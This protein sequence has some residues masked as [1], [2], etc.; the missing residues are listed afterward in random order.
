MFRIAPHRYLSAAGALQDLGEAVEPLGERAM[1]V[2]N[3]TAL[4]RF[5]DVIRSSL[6]ES[7]IGVGFEVCLG[8]CCLPEVERLADEA[9]KD[10]A[11]MIIGV[12][13]SNTLDVA[14]FTAHQLDSNLVTL[15][16]VAS[17]YAAFTNLVYL[18]SEDGE[19][20]EVKEL[21]TSPDLTIVDYKVVGL[22]PSRYLRA[23]MGVAIAT[24]YDIGISREELELHQP[25]KISFELSRHLRESLFESGPKALKDVKKGE[26]TGRVESVIEMNV[27]EAGLIS[28]LGGVTFRSMIAHQLARQLYPYS[29]EDILYGEVVS[30]TLIV[31][32]L[33]RGQTPSSL[34]DLMN[35]YRE[36]ELPLTL[37]S[38]GLPENQHESIL[39]DALD[40]VI[41]HLENWD[42]PFEVTHERLTEAVYQA[43]DLGKRVIQSGVE[44][45]E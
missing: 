40:S 39:D 37:D 15:P 7:M 14:K 31:Q 12:G 21:E 20:L 18:Y 42:L 24:S 16:S 17:S 5:E 30:F 43:D 27:L 4:E 2:A 36:V 44:I 23:G 19:F 34:K 1:V 26:V 22:A 13:A 3:K 45:L 25:S 32:Q 11:D 29:S 9:E 33:F 8:E 6:K 35:F 10:N 41:D 28:S 38:I